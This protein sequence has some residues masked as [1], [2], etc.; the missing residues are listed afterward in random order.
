MREEAKTYLGSSTADNSSDRLIVPDADF[1]A[2]FEIPD[3][4]VRAAE[5]MSSDDAVFPLALL[6]SPF[7]AAYHSGVGL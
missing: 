6:P 4:T 3:L 5:L 2:D 1:D 7:S